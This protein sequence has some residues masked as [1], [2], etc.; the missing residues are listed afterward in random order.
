MKSEF[1]NPVT[2]AL[3]NREVQ[4]EHFKTEQKQKSG[5]DKE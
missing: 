5:V 2:P 4:A 3:G 1:T